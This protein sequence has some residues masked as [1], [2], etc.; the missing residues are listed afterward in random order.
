[1][2]HLLLVTIVFIFLQCNSDLNEHDKFDNIKYLCGNFNDSISEL[3]VIKYFDQNRELS[4]DE[5]DVKVININNNEYYPHIISDHGCFAININETKKI[6]IKSRVSNSG[7]AQPQENLVPGINKIDLVP[8]TN[9]MFELV[10]SCG[11][12]PEGIDRLL[13]FKAVKHDNKDLTAFTIDEANQK[14]ECQVNEHSCIFIDNPPD[15]ELNITDEDG[16][17]GKVSLNNMTVP[18]VVNFV[19]LRKPLSEAEICESSLIMKWTASRCQKKSFSE[20]YALGGKTQESLEL[21][22]NANNESSLKLALA[23]S[24]E[25]NISGFGLNELNLLAHDD[26]TPVKIDIRENHIR[27]LSP[28]AH[29]KNLKSLY[30]TDN[31]LSMIHVVP[32]NLEIFGAARNRIRNIQGLS[33]SKKLK[34]VTLK[35]NLIVDL[36]PLT[37]ATELEEL[38]LDN[39]QIKSIDAL[40]ELKK[41]H[42]L[43]ISSNPIHDFSA[44]EGLT[45]ITKLRMQKVGIVSLEPLKNMHKMEILNLTGNHDI[46]D[47]SPLSGMKD[48]HTLWLWGAK[49]IDNLAVIGE[50]PK[51]KELRLNDMNLHDLSFLSRVST[52]KILEAEDNQISSL[53]TIAHLDL[54]TIRLKGNP[55][56]YDDNLYMDDLKCPT[57]SV[58]AI[59][60]YCRLKRAES[61]N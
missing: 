7:A 42:R 6:V 43:W 27:D 59:G 9:D 15:S 56:D 57:N 44:L 31:Y 10:E 33:N 16:K 30:A 38:Y 41:L 36:T 40:K 48:L 26:I 55:I 52:L 53:A 34:S 35:N 8:L 50:F 24:A 60:T 3:A 17:F 25:I 54:D 13:I 61:A 23:S 18:G 28:L 12:I 2:K 47:L 58:G 32:E 37:V 14:V 21:I 49:K 51:M 19:N 5:V 4:L 11:E 22:T 39:N 46:T 29:N 45:N 1:M 20:L